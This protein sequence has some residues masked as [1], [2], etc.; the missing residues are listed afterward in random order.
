[1]LCCCH[2]AGMRCLL[3]NFFYIFNFFTSYP[4]LYCTQLAKCHEVNHLFLPPI[5]LRSLA[6]SFVLVPQ[7]LAMSAPVP[8]LPF[9]LYRPRTRRS[10][11]RSQ[12]PPRRRMTRRRNPLPLPLRS[13]Q[14]PQRSRSPLPTR[15]RTPKVTTLSRCRPLQPPL[16]HQSPQCSGRPTRRT[17]PPPPLPRAPHCFPQRQSLC[18][19]RRNGSRFNA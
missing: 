16:P 18:L 17:R 11:Q 2:A 9:L 10:P 5:Q 4:F 15:R 6:V 19:R 13:R 14:S 1:M 8:L 3:C 12:S 7:C